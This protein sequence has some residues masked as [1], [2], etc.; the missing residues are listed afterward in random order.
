MTKVLY[1]DTNHVARL[2]MYIQGVY[3]SRRVYIYHR[4][5]WHLVFWECG[6]KKAI[7]AS[8]LP[9]YIQECLTNS[10]L[11]GEQGCKGLHWPSLPGG[12]SSSPAGPR[13]KQWRV[14]WNTRA[15]W[16]T[17]FP[18]RLLDWMP[19]NH[20]HFLSL[21]FIPVPFFLYCLQFPL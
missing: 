15:E 12:L 9:Q 4:S 17:Y 6:L 13:G 3:T 11:M 2:S 7:K 1:C 18:G 10:L 8:R 14:K 19:L 21:I 20:V 16:H 5:T